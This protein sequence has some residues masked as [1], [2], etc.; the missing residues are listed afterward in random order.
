MKNFTYKILLIKPLIFSMVFVAGLLISKSV[1]AQELAIDFGRSAPEVTVAEDNMQRLV[2]NFS[3]RGISTFKVETDRGQFNEISIPGLYST[4]ELGTPKLPASKKLFE[5]PFGAE[6]T[7]K[8]KNYTLNEYHLADHGIELPLMPV[9]PSIRKDQDVTE[10]N[11]EFDEEIYNKD[12]FI[13]PELATVEILGVMRGY[14]IARLTV[15]PVSYNP[16]KGILRVMNDIEVEI[17]YT[18]VDA[19]LTDYIKASTWSPYFEVVQNM[20]INDLR[21]GYPGHPD[22]TKYPVK[23]LIVSDRMFENDLQEFID[24]KTMKGFEVILAF[25]D[26]IGAT[27]TQIQTWVHA[28]Y[29]QGT[30]TDPAPSFLLIV[31]DVQQVPAQMGSSSGKMTDLYYGSVD[32]D[33]FPEMYYG[34][35]SATS[36]AQLVSQIAKT[37]YYEKYEFA[38]PTYLN[39][40]TLIAG[41]D[42]TW[43]P[44]VGQPT[45]IYG[46]DNYF[47]AAHGFN[48]VNDYLTSPYTGCYDPE[49]IA[50]SLIN[51][52]AHCHQTVWGD[53]LLNQTMVN[54]FV[55]NGKYPIAIGNCCLAADFGHTECIGE[56]WQRA[57]NK[58]SVAYIGSSPNSYWFEDFYWAVGAFPIQG[59]NNGYV[60][61][62]DETTWGV[63]D[64][65]FVSDYVTT[66]SINFVGN[67][68]VTEVDIQNY[69]SHSSPLYYWQA[70][71][72][73]GDPSL[74]PYYT[75]GSENTV[76]HMA[77]LPIGLETYEVTAEPGSYVGISKDGV[78]HG[79][80]LVG[81]LGVVEVPLEPVLSSGMVDIVVTKPQRI[82]YIMQVPAAALEGPYVVLD[83]YTINDASGNNN[84]LADYGED[85]SLNVTLKNVGADPSANVTATVTGTDQYVTLTSAASQS[86]GA[87]IDGGTA[88]VDNAYSFSI[89]DF[90]PDQH[91][92]HFELEI[93][94]G[95]DTWTSNLFITVQA[96]VMTIS[97]DFM[98]DDSQSGN[99]D[100]ILDPGETALVKL[101]IKNTGNSDVSDISVT[102]VSND[103]LLI[104]NTPD[105]NVAS[106]AAGAS[107]EIAISV[108][109]DASAPIG[110]PV[111]V[112]LD[113]EAGPDGAY[114]A[115]QM[116]TVVIGLIPEYLMTNATITTCVGLF[117]DS[118]GPNGQYGN[119]ENFTM[120]FLPASPDG[121]IKA[122]FLSFN[123][124][125][126]YDYLYIYN[127]PDASSPQFPGSPFHGEVN[128]GLFVGL[129]AQGAI[130]FRFTSDGSVTRDGWE[131]EISCHYLSGVPEC[132]SDPG[133]AD[134]AENVSLNTDL[135]WVSLDA[136]EFDVYFGVVPNPPFV[137]TASVPTY[138]PELMPSTT[139]FW[140]I[141]PKNAN[142]TAED[143]PVWSFTTGGPEYLMTNATVTVTNG[144]FYDSGGPDGNYQNNE[145]YTMTFLP[146]GADQ[147]IVMEFL[148]FEVESHATCNWDGLVIY[149]GVDTNAPEIGTFCGTDS[150]GTVEATNDAGALTFHFYSDGSVTR[151]GWTAAFEAMGA[152]TCNIISI[153]EEIC[154]GESAMLMANPSGGTG[155][156]NCTWSPPE[157][158][159]DPN[160]PNPIATP[161]VTTTY[162]VTID[163]GETIITDSYTLMVHAAPDVDLGEDHTVCD[164]DIV[165]LDATTPD[166]VSYYWEPGGHTTAVIQ[167]DSTGV[168]H[169]S[170]V[171]TAHVTGPNGCVGVDE[172]MI[173]FEACT[174]IISA[175]DDFNLMIYP[176]PAKN[177]L[178]I[179]LNG[180]SESVTFSLLNYQGQEVHTQQVGS[181]SGAV[182]YSIS[183]DEFARGVY[184]LR[185]NTA[186]DV[187][188]RKVVL[189]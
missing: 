156:Y 105:I 177:L 58:G 104:I 152:L 11:F 26:E 51:Y 47:N 65:P 147:V 159:S 122:N 107:H 100:N 151:P 145:N 52:T 25:T 187:I 188:I 48:N 30:P 33:Y 171:Y 150:P 141:V 172:V 22:L 158:L 39:D 81:E 77:I 93:T 36:S 84:G 10:I 121:V 21:N 127:G 9:Q 29:N 64:A 83:G 95:S 149:D 82:P 117:Y 79:S 184:Y 70:Y 96:P 116:I 37:L 87:I 165:T 102:I 63:Y 17:S 50:V 124:E 2:T 34:R 57:A 130:T 73:L 155:T 131:A 186:D 13:E 180:I 32:G 144:M 169:G 45:V 42:G 164:Y 108:T 168:G 162:T 69:P 125:A 4:G 119:N 118:G 15:A 182:T 94:D 185:L 97:P 167:V 1:S 120:T 62:Y 44:R 23:Y 12:F 143:C 111:N 7:V 75:E 148:M 138:T 175:G 27:F 24:W 115:D 68:A 106:L 139:Y 132:A 46:T 6:V 109:A 170:I 146:A 38:D 136:V 72:V 67:L 56:T 35:F 103:P 49:R 176:N 78:L 166:G 101:E 92:A 85:I 61:S 173:T 99:N 18:G 140:K 8:V 174:G 55:N 154:Q 137:A 66:G 160:I 54:N 189:Q 98:I 134:G 161:D 90:V 60:P 114:V 86:F 16:A 183:L 88:T 59:T 20:L 71:N 142:G 74:V 133:P 153:P 31:G 53:P 89:A 128:P 129:N 76:S 123:T 112:D 80:A 178:N 126:T 5:I 163:D 3:F 113:L 28:Q 110:Y 179:S 19:E 43:N 41:A 157:S 135:T 91:K 40:V 181:L 14:R